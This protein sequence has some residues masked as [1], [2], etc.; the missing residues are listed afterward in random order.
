MLAAEFYK[1][2]GKDVVVVW[3]GESSVTLPNVSKPV[4]Y[5]TSNDLI[6]ILENAFN[7]GA[8][9]L[10]KVTMNHWLSLSLVFEDEIPKSLEY[11][12]K[13]LGPITYLVG[14]SLSVSDLAVFSVL[15]GR[16]YHYFYV[17][18]KTYA[19]LIIYFI[20][21]IKLN[22]LIVLLLDHNVLHILYLFYII[23]PY[24][25]PTHSSNIVISNK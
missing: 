4:P 9:P 15:Y 12:D 19:C 2:V 20:V 1:S 13:T 7:K 24:H 23:F 6:R 16:C 5:A 18:A 17:S 22:L 8:G 25:I 10:Q 3:G 21:Q 14:E 11:L